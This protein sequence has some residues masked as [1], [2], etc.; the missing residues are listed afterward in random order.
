MLDDD[1]SIGECV[2]ALRSPWGARGIFHATPFATR[3]VV[4]LSLALSYRISGLAT[5]GYHLVNLAIHLEGV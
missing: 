5:W 3:P 4:G 1:R 2:E